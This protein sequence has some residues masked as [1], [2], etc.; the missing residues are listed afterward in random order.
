MF[1]R[2]TGFLPTTVFSD[3]TKNFL[4]NPSPA[5]GEVVVVTLRC[6]QNGVD[7]VQLVAGDEI[8]P[9][10]KA[11]TRGVFD[12]YQTQLTMDKFVQYYFII[13]SG[14]DKYFYNRA[15]CK[16]Y[17]NAEHNFTIAPDF[18]VPDWAKGAVM[19][20]IFIDRFCNGD[21]ANDVTNEQY[22]YLG[23]PTKQMKWDDSV[24]A[25]D[26]CNF[27]GGDLAGIAQ[28]INYLAELGVEALY[29][30]PL[31]ASPS[32]H[33]YD[34]S[35]YE[36]VD[37]CFG[38]NQLLADLIAL[39][40]NHG[41][42]VILDGV[43]N[44]CGHLHRWLDK[45]GEH[46]DHFLWNGDKYQAWWGHD[47]H[48]KL[49]FEGSPTLYEYMLK[50]GE[51]W[52]SPPYNAD[53][54]RLDVAADLGQSRE[55][56]LQFWKDFR[57][58]VRTANPKALILAEHYGDPRYWLAGDAWDT[59][60]NY[61][62]FM[63][64]VSGFFTGMQKHSEKALPHLLG[65]AKAFR[66]AVSRYM[67][68][69]PFQARITA[70][71]QLSNHDHSRFLTRTNGRTGRLHTHGTKTADEGLN[72]AIMLS[73]VVL[74]F[75]W[76]G[77]PTIYYGDEAGLT[78]WTDPDNRR[79]YPWGKENPTML[80]FHK[81]ITSIHKAHPALRH[82]SLEFLLVQQDA[83]VF[84]RWDDN[85]A[86]ICAF[87]TSPTHKQLAIPVWRVGLPFDA[88]LTRIL[89]TADGGFNTKKIKYISDEGLI[90]VTLPPFSSCLINFI[91]KN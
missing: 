44:H 2:N 3:E 49:N 70:M 25:V 48:P 8:Y 86:L 15:G 87:N 29:L 18:Y 16:G 91:K 37:P 23:R 19:Y 85:Q 71:N 63:E 34:I 24:E 76:Q 39:A 45:D 47:N 14:V 1:A 54:W 72:H 41:I 84:A 36:N 21:P 20:Q 32:N 6:G 46:A 38:D 77:C 88:T 12:F 64:P 35:D 9:M 82:G 17:F 73:A 75:T 60:M 7:T 52:V 79:P 69:I 89:L 74:Q 30:T 57:R 4:S 62:G 10:T 66:D 22:V 11:Y 13:Y 55:F 90:F 51:K 67:S 28:K 59:V 42:K 26:I 78:G 61:D 65:D 80:A 68:K 40:H 27:Y 81:E 43:F 83:L 53:G 5:T 58:R 33:K 50:I 31:F 56:N